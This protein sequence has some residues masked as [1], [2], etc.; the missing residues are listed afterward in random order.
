MSD[1]V[2]RTPSRD[3]DPDETLEWL[4]SLDYALENYGPDRVRFLLKKL[5]EWTQTAGVEFPFSA[6][7]AYVNSIPADPQPPSPGNREIER[8]IKSIIRWNAMAMV[9][10]ANR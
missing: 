2:V 10:R 6:N 4:E 1:K 9:V 3:V 8:R 7:T 5:E